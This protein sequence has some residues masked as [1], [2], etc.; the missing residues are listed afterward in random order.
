MQVK[1]HKNNVGKAMAIL[2]RKLADEGILQKAREKMYY[3]KPSDRKRR[4]RK[5]SIRAARKRQEDRISGNSEL[6]VQRNGSVV[7]SRV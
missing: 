3:E 6:R 2:N 4:K 7:K 5:E 1:V